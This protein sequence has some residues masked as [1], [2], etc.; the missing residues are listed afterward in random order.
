MSVNEKKLVSLIIACVIYL[1]ST[2]FIPIISFLFLLPFLM[3]NNIKVSQQHKIFIISLFTLSIFCIINQV[4]GVVE[5]ESGLNLSIIYA[6]PYFIII[7]LTSLVSLLL[8]DKVIKYLSIM[9]IF[10]ICLGVIQYFMGIQDFSGKP[11]IDSNLLY[12]KNVSG[13]SGNSS[14]LAFKVF[15]LAIFYKITKPSGKINNYILLGFI[16]VGLLI[17]FNR[18]IIIAT[19]LLIFGSLWLKKKKLMFIAIIVIFILAINYTDLIIQQLFRGGLDSSN[20]YSERDVLYKYYYDFIINNPVLGNNSYKLLYET[21]DGRI[22]HAHNSYLQLFANHGLII[23]SLFL[24]L[25]F[26]NMSTSSLGLMFCIFITGLLQYSIFWGASLLDLVMYYI[27]FKKLS[28]N[29][30]KENM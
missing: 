22:L 17:T 7:I 13:L 18:T 1:S 21:H 2:S 8:D 25:I 27:L 16:F 29:F 15:C 24:I 9:I 30:N 11:I 26:I 14:G 6:L 19:L 28:R 12:D 20:V 3:F 4:Y 23:S 10:E 5:N